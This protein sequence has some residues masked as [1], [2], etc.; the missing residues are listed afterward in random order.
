MAFQRALL[1]AS[2]AA[3]ILA[4]AGGG[5]AQEGGQPAGPVAVKGPTGAYL[6]LKERLSDK[7]SD[8]QRVNNC[9]V[10]PERRGPTERP[11]GCKSGTTDT[12]PTR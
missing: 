12:A 5:S 11:E 4:G 3:A 6:T 9:G 8:E 7:A 1:G 2:V 10:P